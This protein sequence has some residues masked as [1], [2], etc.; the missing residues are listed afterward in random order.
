MK[1]RTIEIK[2]DRETILVLNNKGKKINAHIKKKW[3]LYPNKKPA[4]VATAFPPLN[5]KK[6]EN[7]CPKIATNP[8]IR[9]R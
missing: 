4:D 1:I 2:L 8:K 9:Q 5:F 7:A 3:T 6:I